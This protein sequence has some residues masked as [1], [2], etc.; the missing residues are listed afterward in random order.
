MLPD[1]QS[2]ASHLSKPAIG[3]IS[4]NKLITFHLHQN[5]HG[6]YSTIFV[7]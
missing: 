7:D 1:F 4:Y 3:F 6:Q 5:V 2:Q